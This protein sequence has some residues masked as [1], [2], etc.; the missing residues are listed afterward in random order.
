MSNP[1]QIRTCQLLLE[2]QQTKNLEARNSLIL[3]YLPVINAI[4]EQICNRLPQNVES[5]DLRSAGLF[6][7]MDAINGFDFSKGTQFGTYCTIRIRGSILDELRAQDWVPRV[8]RARSQKLNKAYQQ[9]LSENGREPTEIEIAQS[10]HLSVEEYQKFVKQASIT[11]VTPLSPHLYEE[12]EG[13]HSLEQFADKS[14]QEPHEILFKKEI[15]EYLTRSL[16]EK[17]RLILILY[18]FEELPMKEIGKILSISE[19]RISQ[20]HTRLLF[21]LRSQ[22]DKIKMEFLS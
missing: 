5:E 4:S 13:Y 12:E 10:L 17:E 1:I 3:L 7:L 21:R 6:G 22:F 20:I 2:Y 8:V 18:Y 14:Q 19:S 9:L 15:L 11:N 16:C